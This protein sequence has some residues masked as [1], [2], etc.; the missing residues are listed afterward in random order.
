MRKREWK[1]WFMASALCAVM[2][3]STLAVVPATEVQAAKEAEF[4]TATSQT[5]EVYEIGTARELADFVSLVNNGNNFYGQV[6]K[7][8]ADISLNAATVDNISSIKGFAGV[9]DGAGYSISG[10]NMASGAGLFDSVKGAVI[11]NLTLRNAVIDSVG[12]K[13]V[14]G[15]VACGEDTTIQN[16]HVYNI[17]IT[18]KEVYLVGGILGSGEYENVGTKVLNCS[19]IGGSIQ[20]TGV[21]IAGWYSVNNIVGGVAGYAYEVN[22]CC[23]TASVSLKAGSQSYVYLGGIVGNVTAMQNC[24]NI[25]TVS[26]ETELARDEKYIGGIAGKAGGV[27]ANNYCLDTSCATA[28]GYAERPSS[29]NKT[30]TATY[31]QSADFLNQL[32][33]NIGANYQWFPWEKRAESVYPLPVKGINLAN[34]T[35]SLAANTV[36]YNGLEQKPAVS[37]IYNGKVLVENEDYTLEYANNTE[38]GTASVTVSGA[39]MYMGAVTLNFTITKGT[40]TVSYKKSYS[41]TYGDSEFKLDFSI[42]NSADNEITYTC[43][44]PKMLSVDSYGDVTILRPGKTTITVQLPETDCYFGTTVKITV[45]VKPKKPYVY[46]SSKSKALYINWYRDT[47]VTGYELQVSTDSKFKKGVKKYTYKSNKTVK[48]TL[49]KLKTG[50][51]YYV[52]IRSYKTVSGKKLYS[53]WSS[54]KAIKIKK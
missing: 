3:W 13:C 38:V 50:K 11:K 32:N 5:A 8:T 35:L 19:V 44:N 31:M 16:C 24:F 22:N 40:P 21:G 27:V 4:A 12:N 26:G 42:T 49:K 45:T 36:E 52:R 54:K 34:C 7:L 46:L 15:I 33:G 41:K 43:S 9:F 39:N 17:S 28:I 14:G 23:N 48:K 47:T 25:G 10:I 1:T 6:V 30:Y 51:K 20:V 2:V 37:V 53:S 18:A 29:T